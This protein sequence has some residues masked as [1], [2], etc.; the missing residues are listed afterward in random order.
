VTAPE[1]IVSL[2]ASGTELVCALGLGDRLVGRSHECDFPEWVAR[3]PVVSRPL[4]D[5]TGSSRE[6]DERV[7]SR[8]RDNLPLYQVD[9]QLLLAL[10]PEVL[11]TQ[12]HCE[13]CAV[14]P[15][16]VPD[17]A[18]A[19]LVRTP[20]VDLRGNTLSE[21]VGGFV[22]AA[23]LLAAEDAGRSLADRLEAALREVRA[24]VAPRPRP[25]VACI[26][27]VDPIFAMGNWGPELVEIAGGENVLGKAGQHSTTASFAALQEADPDVLVIAPC[28]FG[29]ERA[30]VEMKHLAVVPGFDELRAVKEGRVFVCDGNRYFNRSSPSLFETPAILAEILHPEQA[31]PSYAGRAWRRWRPAGD[32]A[33]DSDRSSV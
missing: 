6:I 33:P 32:Q 4:F 11:I 24:R 28:G 21:I 10:S 1:R 17:L 22:E 9:E 7:R 16:D 15:A 18:A 13:V 26:E 12:T 29:L 31:A 8:L 25:R 20:V 30:S 2:L 23:R 5:V 27:W 19:R 14:G 3:L